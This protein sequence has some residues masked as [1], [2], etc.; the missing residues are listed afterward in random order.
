MNSAII[1]T[2]GAVATV[3]GAG[4]FGA[5]LVRH[6]T[7]PM[8]ALSGVILLSFGILVLVTGWLMGDGTINRGEALKTGGLAAGSVVALYALWLNDRRRR[9]EEMRQEIEAARHELETRRTDH[10][11]ERAAD[12][13]FARAIELL[14]STADQVRV[15]AMHALV[16]LSR[17]RPAYTQTV[18]DVL[19]AYLR[20]PFTYDEQRD[21]RELQVRTTAQRLIADL[22]PL[23]SDPDAPSYDLD[24]HGA[25]LEYFD[26]R[27]RLVGQ[28]RARRTHLYESTFFNR[29]VV[30]GPAWFTGSQCHGRFYAPEV[31]FHDRS[32]FSHFTADGEVDFTG[33]VFHGQT[34][35]ADSEF[36]GKVSFLDAAFDHGVNFNNVRFANEIDLRVAGGAIGHTIAMRVSLEH[37]Y[38]L[39]DGWIVDTSHGPKF[40]LVRA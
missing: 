2:L 22:L 3:G 17:S 38:Q 10:D 35:F 11:R 18:L 39:P 37:E 14:G 24:L 29:V 27:D 21:E 33:G 9:T 32:W 4:V 7:R 25:T 5:W 23:A 28:L 26:I 1:V 15:G 36:H 8:G 40:G 19:C 31:V 30:R 12:E 34:K 13:R 6:R 16:G 20:R